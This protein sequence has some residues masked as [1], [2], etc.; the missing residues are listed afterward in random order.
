MSLKNSRLG[1]SYDNS[2]VQILKKEIKMKDQQ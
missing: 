2:D 1:T